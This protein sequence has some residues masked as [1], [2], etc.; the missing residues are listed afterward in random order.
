MGQ[1]KT[2]TQFRWF[3]IPQ[4]KQEEEY[5]GDMHGKGWKFTGVT[6][7]GVYHFEQC[8]PENVTY[9]LDYNQEGIANKQEYVQLFADCG[10]EYLLDFVG[11]S[12]FRKSLGDTNENEEIFCDDESRL[13]M[14]KRVFR[15]RIVPLI[16]IFFGCILPQ[17]I[18]NMNGHSGEWNI[19]QQVLAYSLLG[20]GILYVVMFG[21]LT[22]QFYRYEKSINPERDI[23]LKYIG[24][25]TGLITILAI[26]LGIVIIANISSYNL[27]DTENGFVIEAE[28]LNKSIV[29]EY[30]LKSGD[31]ICV[32]H[33]GESGELYISIG[34]SNEKP[35][36]YGNTYDEFR[37]FEVEIQEAGI[38]Q[39]KCSGKRASGKIEI[40]IN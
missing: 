24:I 38:Y 29:K 37:K 1:K 36:F 23:K 30:E 16:I 19:V 2:K 32:N 25:A 4:Y 5:L 35:V 40:E 6:F 27:L 20:V 14:M 12:Y 10:W 7:P 21:K 15:G 31:I 26:M 11:Y 28:K 3:T 17:F 8:E 22:W 13:D 39:I 18:M 34:Q 9:R 33:E